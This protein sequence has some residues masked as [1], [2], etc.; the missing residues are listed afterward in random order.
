MSKDKPTLE[1]RMGV[2]EAE[3]M[4]RTSLLEAVLDLDPG[5]HQRCQGSPS[6]CG[7]AC[8]E[9][10]C[11]MRNNRV[12]EMGSIMRSLIEEFRW[13]RAWAKELECLQ[14]VP[15]GT[16]ERVALR[17]RVSQLRDALHSAELTLAEV[18]TMEVLRNE[19]TTRIREIEGEILAAET[20]LG[21]T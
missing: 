19:V 20:I 16:Q 4:Q 17:V 1:Q 15:H 11:P 7:D 10:A 12:H 13:H 6:D 2:L 5:V 18:G 9:R 8:T 14:A 3:L 21:G